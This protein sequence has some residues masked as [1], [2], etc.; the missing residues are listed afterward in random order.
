MIISI[1]VIMVILFS[2]ATSAFKKVMVG[3]IT[4]SML[5]HI[6]IHKKAI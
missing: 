3:Q 2:G 5:G 4:D 1:G 6:Q